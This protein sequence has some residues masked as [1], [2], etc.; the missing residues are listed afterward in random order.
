MAVEDDLFEFFETSTSLITVN[1]SGSKEDSQRVIRKII[2][3]DYYIPLIIPSVLQYSA[4]LNSDNFQELAER[5]DDILT[6]LGFAVNLPD[7]YKVS[8]VMGLSLV[9]ALRR[10]YNHSLPG[11]SY[12]ILAHTENRRIQIYI[13]HL[14]NLYRFILYTR[15]EWY[16]LDNLDYYNKILQKEKKWGYVKTAIPKRKSEIESYIREISEYAAKNFHQDKMDYYTE[17]FKSILG[18]IFA[19]I[20]QLPLILAYTV[21]GATVVTYVNFPS[22]RYQ[23]HTTVLADYLVYS[24]FHSDLR[25]TAER[26]LKVFSAVYSAIPRLPESIKAIN[27]ELTSSI[28]REVA[29]SAMVSR[30]LY[31][32]DDEIKAFFN[33]ITQGMGFY[34]LLEEVKPEPPQETNPTI[35]GEVLEC[36]H[37]VSSLNGLRDKISLSTGFTLDEIVSALSAGNLLFVGPP[38]TGKTRTVKDLVRALTGD[39]NSCYEVYTAN[40]LWFR[41]DV[42]GGESIVQGTAV[43]RSGIL[44]RAYVNAARVRSGLYYL[45]L[46][47]VNRADVDKAFGEFFTVFSENDPNSWSIPRSL[48]EEIESFE[49]RRDKYADEFVRLYWNLGDEPL[50]RIRIVATM[51]L[52]DVRNAFYV[53]DAFA[54]RFTIVFFRA[55][56]GSEDVELV[57][58]RD[59]LSIPDLEDI[60]DF[61]SYVR[62]RLR[63]FVV[64][65]ASV[66]RALILYSRL[67]DKGLE[68]FARLLKASLGTL[69][70]DVLKEYDK[71]VEDYFGGEDEEGQ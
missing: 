1:I 29:I 51:N 38:G 43:W 8:T 55:P 20:L 10:L 30:E 14:L 24:T 18:S 31:E 33:R 3:D 64:S 32:N 61:V 21:N 6:E 35:W 5:A 44:I 50:R 9:V 70:T 56:K 17:K 4:G 71:I 37:N 41:R 62:E 12:Y 47:E 23:F 34:E 13:R 54:R 27:D 45:I 40:S 19:S 53:G 11:E 66:E 48:V 63:G 65:T 42:I 59:N 60:K 46:D 2:L 39:N 52:T 26:L 68:A 58:K 49:G 25:T 15:V 22:L 36:H 67:S 69:N 7:S 28:L 16:Y 57:V